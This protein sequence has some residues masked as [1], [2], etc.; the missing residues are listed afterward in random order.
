MLVDLFLFEIMCDHFCVFTITSGKNIA[1]FGH[2]GLSIL[3]SVF[4]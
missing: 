1:I 3:F 2:F 4:L